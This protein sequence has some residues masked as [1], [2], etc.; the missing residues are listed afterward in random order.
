MGD[1]VGPVREDPLHVGLRFLLLLV[2]E[3]EHG[4]FLEA[5]LVVPR[6]DE[7]VA[8]E[9]ERVLLGEGSAQ[10]VEGGEDG[11]LGDRLSGEGVL[12]EAVG[13][14]CTERLDHIAIRHVFPV[15]FLLAASRLGGGWWTKRDSN[16][17]TGSNTGSRTGHPVG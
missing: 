6:D 10:R 4:G 2:G 13:C 17:I 15:L 1:V 3:Q 16:P 9:G 12:D 14:G 7:L 8:F 5:P 11:G